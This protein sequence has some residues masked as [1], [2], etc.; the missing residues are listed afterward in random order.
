MNSQPPPPLSADARHRA[1]RRRRWRQLTATAVLVALAIGVWWLLGPRDEADAVPAFNARSGPVPVR[2]AEV[3]QRALPVYLTALGTATPLN[4]VTV[5]SRVDGELVELV[6]R[7]GQP[8]EAGALLARIDPRPYQVALAEAEGQQ[9]QNL[10]LLENARSTLELYQGLWKQDSIA[11][12]ELDDQ[13]A[14]VR[15][16]E[17]MVKIDQARVDDASLDL[18][19]TEI[20][21]PIAGTLGLRSVD[22]GNLISTGDADGLMTITQMDPMSVLFSLPEAELPALLAQWRTDEAL[23]V[24]A[25]DRAGRTP[26]ATGILQTI[27]NRIDA[28]TGT[29]RLRALFENDDLSLFPNQFV[30]VRLQLRTEEDALVVPSAAV[31][32]GSA[33]P[34]LY[35]IRDDDTAQLRQVTLGA[36]SGDL[37]AI[38]EGIAAGERV[39][40]E[41][42]ERLRDGASVNVVATGAGPGEAVLQDRI[43]QPRP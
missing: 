2:A 5:R 31:Q 42:V 24:E 38:T 43:E 28:T 39:V 1:E 7:E 6:A 8:V 27:D 11:R 37:T 13:A 26:L 14:L 40:L 23:T 32:H 20:K 21:A 19:F 17:G 9:Q 4:T 12:Q 3:D 25:W 15:Q 29:V 35:V 22:V 34:Y 16:Y 30:N 41:G 33:G 10:A 36:V 18:S